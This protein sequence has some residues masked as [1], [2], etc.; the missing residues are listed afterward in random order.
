MSYSSFCEYLFASLMNLLDH[1]TT[2]TKE[3]IRKNNNVSLDAFVIHIP[4]SG[5]APVIYLQPLYKSYQNGSSIDKISQLIIS[6]LKKEIPLSQELLQNIQTF[7]MVRDRIVFRLISQKN[8]ET[9]LTEVPWVPFLDLAVTF[10]LHLGVRDNNQITSV[11]HNHQA[12]LWNLSPED[13]Y[14]LAK[15]NTPRIYPS[16][17]S[18]MEHLLF[19]WNEDEGR[20]KPCETPLPPLYV[21]TNQAG[22]NGASCLLYDGIIKDFADRIGSDLIILP[23]SIHE[24]LL[25]P[26][27]HTDEYDEF[28]QMVQN[29]NAEEVPKEDI[30]SDDLYL[31]C[32]SSNT[33]ITKWIPCGSGSAESY[34][35]TNP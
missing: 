6:R 14:T 34:G 16:T 11:I 22:I 28:R 18:R 30:L 21:L 4:G 29:I 3:S 26:D 23:S 5:S 17:L 24:V 19:G 32:R 35:T 8:N 1:N 33:G 13:L 20:L 15:E 7:D 10:Y 25:L 12:K 27:S 31:Y 9:L 2:I